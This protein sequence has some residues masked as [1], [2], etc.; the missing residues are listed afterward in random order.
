MGVGFKEE[1]DLT[2]RECSNLLLNTMPGEIKERKV[3]QKLFVRYVCML[4]WL[5]EFALIVCLIIVFLLNSYLSRRCKFLEDSVYLRFYK[6][7]IDD[8][9][10]GGWFYD[11]YKKWKSP[12]P[13]QQND[14]H[15]DPKKLRS[16]LLHLMK[17]EVKETCVPRKGTG[18]SP[19]HLQ[20]SSVVICQNDYVI[21]LT[22]VS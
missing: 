14:E 11:W 16:Q 9:T 7:R 4:Y 15:C 12:S 1:K 13:K 20:V 10:E 18:Y 21:D 6:G 5:F 2:P 3:Y 22:L 8:E 17:E 19:P